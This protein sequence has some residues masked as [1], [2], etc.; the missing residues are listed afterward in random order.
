ME[1]KLRLE[2]AD[3]AVSAW[4]AAEERDAFLV[5]QGRSDPVLVA[6]MDGPFLRV[7]GNGAPPF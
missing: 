7:R 2:S 6:H 5:I 1:G 3:A 4:F